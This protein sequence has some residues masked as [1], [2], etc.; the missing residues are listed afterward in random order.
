MNKNKFLNPYELTTKEQQIVDLITEDPFITAKKL[1]KALGIK[2]KSTK[3]HL[4]NIHR[5]FK[6]HRR[7]ELVK[8]LPQV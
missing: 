6:V 8:K 3:F 4:T 2:A 5:K 1:G 7:G